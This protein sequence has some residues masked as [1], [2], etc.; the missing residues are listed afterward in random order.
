MIFIDRVI[1]NIMKDHLLPRYCYAN[2]KDF[3]CKFQK[4]DCKVWCKKPPDGAIPAYQEVPK[5]NKIV[6]KYTKK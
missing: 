3:F 6:F 4:C 1:R 2:K 5:S